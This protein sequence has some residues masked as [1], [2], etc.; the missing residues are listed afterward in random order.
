MYK[1]IIHIAFIASFLAILIGFNLDQ[2]KIGE[3]YFKSRSKTQSVQQNQKVELEVD[4]STTINVLGTFVESMLHKLLATN[5][6]DC[7]CEK[8]KK[9]NTEFKSIS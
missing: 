1:K 8:N 4:F 6:I 9:T 5:T 3:R 2:N 7:C